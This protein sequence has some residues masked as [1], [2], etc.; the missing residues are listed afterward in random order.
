MKIL[1]LVACV[2]I[3]GI[4]VAQTDEQE[5]LSYTYAE[6]RF[7]VAALSLKDLKVIGPFLIRR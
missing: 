1:F 7:V 3:H 4:A 2:L 6:L 5:D